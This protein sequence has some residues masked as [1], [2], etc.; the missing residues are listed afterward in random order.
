MRCPNCKNPNDSDATICQWCGA[1]CAPE[2]PPSSNPEG[3]TLR[4][5]VKEGNSH[6]ATRL[7]IEETGAT[8]REAENHIKKIKKQLEDRRN[9]KKVLL[10]ILGL[11]LFAILLWLIFPE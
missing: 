8:V 11:M 10:G 6:L 3:K 1:R 4:Q 2:P 5:L 9:D 7:Y